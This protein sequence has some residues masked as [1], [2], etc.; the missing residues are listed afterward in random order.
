MTNDEIMALTGNE[1]DCAVAISQNFK[2]YKVDP[3]NTIIWLSGEKWI[4]NYH[5]STNGQQ[6][7]EIMSSEKIGVTPIGHY[8]DLWEAESTISIV[9]GRYEFICATGKTI[10]EAVLRCHL[11]SK[12]KFSNI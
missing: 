2:K 12:K 3:A 4:G 1:L 10:N 5:P 6:L 7:I 9:D 8:P 11:L